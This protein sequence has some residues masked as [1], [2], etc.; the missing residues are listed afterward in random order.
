MLCFN[1]CSCLNQ[2]HN[3]IFVTVLTSKVKSCS[4][5]LSKEHLNIGVRQNNLH[6][7]VRT[8]FVLFI[9]MGS[10][11]DQCFS[12]VLVT[13]LTRPVKRCVCHL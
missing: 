2:H 8:D 13:F 5:I 6:A 10:K 1:V 4:A 9:D 7:L 12:S 3:D 11:P